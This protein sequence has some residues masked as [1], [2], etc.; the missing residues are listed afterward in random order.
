MPGVE[1]AL[2]ELNC[3]SDIKKIRFPSKKKKI[4]NRMDYIESKKFF[5][6]SAFALNSVTKVIFYNRHTHKMRFLKMKGNKSVS[7]RKMKLNGNI[8]RK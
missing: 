2:S 7:K 6:R 4:L 5:L 1:I 8:F 3:A